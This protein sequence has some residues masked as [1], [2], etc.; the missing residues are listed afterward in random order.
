MPKPELTPCPFCG[1]EMFIDKEYRFLHRTK[2]QKVVSIFTKEPEI[3]AYFS[4]CKCC[5]ALGPWTK[6][7]AGAIRLS[8]MRVK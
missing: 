3:W 6:N 4:Q 8:N 5:G 2:F 7:K 1:G